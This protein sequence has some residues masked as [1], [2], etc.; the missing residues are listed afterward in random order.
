MLKLIDKLPLI[1]LVLIAVF[2]SLAPFMPE[3]HLVEKLRMLVHG[4][5]IRPIDIFDL[6]WHSLFMVLL[7]IR[8]LR[9]KTPS[10]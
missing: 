4:E 6:L 3:P 1:P 2:M 8:L 7:L 5:L 9:L 10:S